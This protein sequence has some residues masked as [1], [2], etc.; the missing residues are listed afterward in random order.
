QGHTRF[1]VVCPAAVVVNW[2][3]EVESK[4]GL[5]ARR[6]H[7]SGRGTALDEWLASG[8]VGVTSFGTLPWLLR[9]DVPPGELGAVVVDEA[10]YIKNPDAKRSRRVARLLDGVDHVV[11]MTGT[12]LLNRLDEFRALVDQV[13]PDLLAE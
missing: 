6:L 13:R 3:R 1:L 12:P 5:A 4:T 7:G 8:G 10:H 2:V 9:H 11:L